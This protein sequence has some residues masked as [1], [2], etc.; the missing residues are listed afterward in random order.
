[1]NILVLCDDYWHPGEVIRRGLSFLSD[2]HNLDFV[3]DAKDILTP[4]FIRRYDVIVNAKMNELKGS[5][6]N[7]WIGESIVEVQVPDL[8]E[9]VKEG[10]GFIA[11]HGGNAW[12]WDH[13]VDRAYCEFVGNAFVKHPPRCE[14]SMQ[15]VGKHPI[16]DGIQPFTVRDE[17]YELDH[18]AD[19]ITVLMEG[20]SE[21]GGK[22]VAAY[23]RKSGQGRICVLVPGHIL[24]VFENPAYRQMIRQ[25]IDWCAGK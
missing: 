12:Y 23:V 11:L 1:M 7:P 15:P 22:Q 25:A 13:D 16:T 4:E 19:D 18:L 20:T 6:R 2:E 9:Y 21:T 17:H 10:H 24:S 14:I 5:N 3:E 8:D